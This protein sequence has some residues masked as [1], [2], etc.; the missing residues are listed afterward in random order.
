MP[1]VGWRLVRDNPISVARGLTHLALRSVFVI[2]ILALLALDEEHS[3][4]P[5][6][7]TAFE[8]EVADLRKVV[9]DVGN[10]DTKL[11]RPV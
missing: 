3:T 8:W 9:L 1:G 6:P 7:L 5:L 4:I 11:P 2:E 10:G